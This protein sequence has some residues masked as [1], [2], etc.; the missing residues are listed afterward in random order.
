MPLGRT[1]ADSLFNAALAL[2]RKG[3]GNSAAAFRP[4]QWEAIQHVLDRRGPLLVVQKTGWGK[5]NVYFIV[6]KILRDAGHGTVLLISPLLSLM[7]NQMAAAERMGVRAE[8]ITSE[9]KSREDWGRIKEMVL[10][11]EVD[12]LLIS[13]ERL[14]ND[15]FNREILTP[16]AQRLG[17]LVV[18][19]AH[20]IS[21]WAHD[22]R[23]DYRRIT[24][25]LQHLPGNLPVLATTATAN[26]RVINDLKQQLGS[27]HVQRGEMSRPSLC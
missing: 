22:F 19:E 12:I 5:S 10:W 2:L 3:V 24:R 8:R 6:T 4:G 23:P 15:S 11:N 26:D 25:I 14:A 1:K 27:L 9:E 16:L 20:C 7:R 17:M 13:P 18:D 21:D